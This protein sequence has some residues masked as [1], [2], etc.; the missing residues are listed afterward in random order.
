MS[1][2]RKSQAAWF[3]VAVCLLISILGI[4]YYV[5]STLTAYPDFNRLEKVM[6]IP[7]HFK[8]RSET[9]NKKVVT[10]QVNQ[11]KFSYVNYYP[12]YEVVKKLIQQKPQLTVLRYPDEMNIK[13]VFSPFQIKVGDEV[14]VSHLELKKAKE[15]NSLIGLVLGLVSLSMAIVIA[16][17]R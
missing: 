14:I 4:G 11:V 8:E 13:E 10:F 3:T 12:K 16:R 17:L 7:S 9:K 5:T 6:G 15:R 1:K 2:K